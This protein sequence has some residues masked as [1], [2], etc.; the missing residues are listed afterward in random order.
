MRISEISIHRPVFATVISL[1]LV[2]LGLVSLSNL[3][4]REY[5]DI[6]APV[7][8][9]QTSYRG[10]GPNIVEEK[11]TQL[12]EDRIAGLEGIDKIRSSSR[13]ERSDITVE[14]TADRDVDAATN[15]IR[16][17]VS[18]VADDLPPEADPPDIAK[19]EADAE[20]IMWLNLTS[21]RL[22]SLELTDYAERVLVDQL[23]ASPGVAMVRI[24]GARRYAVRVW[25]DRQALAARAMTVADI[26]DALRRENVELPAGR[27]E[28][29]EREFA[30]RTDTGLNKVEDFR[31]L[32][33]GRGADGY[34]VRL[35][36]VAEVRL[37][38][39]NERTISR[40]DGIAG[41][42]LGVV[43]VSKANTLQVAHG[44][45][46]TVERLKPGLP[47]GMVLDTNFDRSVFIEA[48]LKE[49]GIAL[50]ISLLLVL[51]VIYLFLGNIRATVIPAVTIPVSIIA[52][53]TF[54]DAMNYSVNVLTLLGMV[55]AIGLVVDDAIVVLE[56][57]YRHRA[58]G[59]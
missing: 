30:L 37:G 14:F 33:I 38:A 9:I 45:N 26:E 16:D 27:L 23:A 41:V 20:P 47:E 8:S 53:L 18:R 49:V 2:I 29:V 36:D 4:V 46:E 7:V 54:M 52:T 32:V 13:D 6:D 22:S 17:R 5:P 56:N 50:V 21:S 39:D 55:L 44:V 59:P 25:I 10:A 35:G 34:L 48:S 58:R 43:Q 19:T 57:I 51:S 31:A 15:D 3:A 24:G 1:L 40:S 28:S 12:I 42:S 11:I